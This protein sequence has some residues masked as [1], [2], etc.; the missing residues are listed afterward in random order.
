M[1]AI[2]V[3]TVADI[4]SKIGTKTVILRKSIELDGISLF[5]KTELNENMIEASEKVLLHLI[6]HPE[7]NTFD[8]LRLQQY[9]DSRSYDFNN[10]LTAEVTTSTIL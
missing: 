7:C 5:G 9:F 1:P 8:E 6:G 3:L 4:T 2:H 10:T